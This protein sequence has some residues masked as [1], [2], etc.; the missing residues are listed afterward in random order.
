MKAVT[1]D[2][3]TEPIS[4]F[5]LRNGLASAT[6]VVC[7]KQMFIMKQV[8]KQRAAIDKRNVILTRICTFLWYPHGA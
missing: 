8:L 1:P 3:E 6:S 5:A 2:A 4:F 7:V